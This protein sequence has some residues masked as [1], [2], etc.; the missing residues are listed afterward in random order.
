MAEHQMRRKPHVGIVAPEFPPDIGGMQTYAYE[1]VM[2]LVGRGHEITV[3]TQ[4][5]EAGEIDSSA[6]Q[7]KPALQRR[8]RIDRKILSEKVD[9][10][11][12]MNA[13]YSWL[14]LESRVPVV[15]SV[16]GNDFLRPYILV[17]RPDLDRLPLLWRHGSNLAPLDRAIGQRLTNRTVR[18]SLPKLSR[19]LTNSRYTEDVLLK[20]YPACRGLTVPAM[21]G[22]S[23]FFFDHPLEKSPRSSESSR[24]VTLCR[25]SEPRKNVDLVIQALAALKADFHFS[26]TVIGDGPLKPHLEQLATRLGL[27]ER[28]NFTGHLTNEEVRRVLGESDLFVLTSSISPES[29]EGFG[30][31]YL[32]ANACGTPVLA[33]RLAGAKEA[34]A[35]NRS[36]YFVDEPSVGSLQQALRRFLEGE[37][38]FLREECRNFARQFQWSRVVDAGEA[39]YH[40]ALR[41]ETTGQTHE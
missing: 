9:I 27:D 3:F 7:V 12:I 38:H 18:R 13:A 31:V 4:P 6:F 2:E 36:G 37:I 40:A 30:I 20:K 8:R 34:V 28:V 22:V 21:V 16:H 33:A 23:K 25:L 17:E 41:E 32:E 39:A 19:I 29:H 24:L 14:A 26:Y 11:H 10:W 5:H 35:E 15:A 1:Y